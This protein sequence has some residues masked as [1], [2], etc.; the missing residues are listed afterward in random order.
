MVPHALELCLAG[1]DVAGH[2]GDHGLLRNYATLGQSRAAGA[3]A[4]ALIDGAGAWRP[5]RHVRLEMTRRSETA[6]GFEVIPKRWSVE[7]TLGWF[8]RSRR[9]RKDDED[10]TDTSEAMI[11]VTIIHVMVRRLARMTPY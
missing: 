5:W 2:A 1:P 7:R 6:Q 4:G 9:L 10:L 3:Y 8:N 11:R